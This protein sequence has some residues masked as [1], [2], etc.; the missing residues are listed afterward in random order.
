MCRPKPYPRCSSYAKEALARAIE[1]KDSVRIKKAQRAYNMTPAG[2]QAFVDAGNLKEAEKYRRIRHSYIEIAKREQ[3]IDSTLKYE[4]FKVEY[5]PFIK[6]ISK[7]IH[8]ALDSLAITLEGKEVIQRRKE[9]HEKRLAE[10]DAKYTQAKQGKTAEEIFA[11][12]VQQRHERRMAQT[13]WKQM[14]WLGFEFENALQ[15]INGNNVIEW[16]GPVYSYKSANNRTS[17]VRIDAWLTNDKG[18]KKPLDAKFHAWE[19][20]KGEANY[21]VPLNDARA[22]RDCIEEHGVFYLLVAKADCKYDRDGSFKEWSYQLAGKKP[23]SNSKNSR[24]RKTG[25]SVREY[26]VYA[27]TEAHLPVDDE[28]QNADGKARL[29]VFSQGK[30]QS[31]ASR[32]EKYSLNIGKDGLIPIM[33]FTTPHGQK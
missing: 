25:A 3:E 18:E 1:S 28:S 13:N 33:K 5:D 9:Q 4:P 23:T 10:I 31:G 16:H 22:I 17:K 30:Q 8:L 7:N 19:N 12:K 14:E 11:L 26:S 27:I 15:G 21:H 24:I 29:K 2:I 20:A 32:A 6:G